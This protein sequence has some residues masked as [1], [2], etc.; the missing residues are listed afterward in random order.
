MDQKYSIIHLCDIYPKRNNHKTWKVL[1]TK[2][3]Q[4]K[5]RSVCG[6]GIWEKE[7]NIILFTN[8][9]SITDPIVPENLRN[10]QARIMGKM[11]EQER[12][13]MEIASSN[14]LRQFFD[15]VGKM[16]FQIILKYVFVFNQSYGLFSLFM[17]ILFMYKIIF[18]IL[19]T[20]ALWVVFN[21]LLYVLFCCTFF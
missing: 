19:L 9:N 8:P 20:A 1:F 2:L 14:G 13:Q 12:N 5:I 10:E 16:T 15:F 7:D 11:P 3:K 6:E 18:R 4:K 17:Y 21:K